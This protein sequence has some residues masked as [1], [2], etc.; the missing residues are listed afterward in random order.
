MLAVSYQNQRIKIWLAIPVFFLWVIAKPVLAAANPTKNTTPHHLA[1][2]TE[3]PEAKVEIL[4]I[5]TP[6]RPKM[7]LNPGR[8]YIA[9]SFP[10]YETEKGFID[11]VDQDWK[12]KV[13]L[14]PLMA[15][16]NLDLDEEWRKLEEEKLKLE[17]LRQ[18]LAREKLGLEKSK[19]AMAEERQVM[20]EECQVMAEEHQAQVS[21]V[22]DKPTPPTPVSTPM[23]YSLPVSSLSKDGTEAEISLPDE[24]AT[25]S[26][27]LVTQL[28]DD[29]MSYL[30]QP[31]PPGQTATLP[32]SLEAL[33]KLRQAKKLDPGNASVNQAL[34]MYSKRYLVYVGLF[35]QRS[36]ADKLV[37]RIRDLG[38]PVFKQPINVKGK[39]V[40][41]ICVGLFLRRDD[42][43]RS[44]QRLQEKLR[45]KDAFL[46]AYKK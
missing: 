19:K 31:A 14:R 13:T 4:N 7:L 2:F 9:V 15:A 46:R 43:L 35:A 18:D 36:K 33:Q 11:I 16:A 12:G 38:L 39:P 8:Y 1:I 6:Y 42:A 3:P 32:E 44:L 28:L 24:S 25:T 41:R 5:D 37:R 30:K 17:R 22:E 34:Q 45:I 27:E 40:I 10:G 29:A 20:A 21:H 26:P 23:P